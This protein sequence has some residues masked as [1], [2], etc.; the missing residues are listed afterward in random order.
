MTALLSGLYVQTDEGKVLPYR[1]SHRRCD[2]SDRAERLELRLEAGERTRWIEAAAREG[3]FSL[4]DWMRD[5]LNGTARSRSLLSSVCQDWNTPRA[6]LDA[7]APMGRI[8]LDPCSNASSIVR[9]R[10]KWTVADDGLPR[11]WRRHGLVY[12]NSPYGDA[13]PAWIAKCELEAKRGVEI[14]A[15]FPARPDT[16]WFERAAKRS[17]V[18]LLRGRLRF[19]GA[20]HGAPF[21]SAVAYWGRRRSLFR[22]TLA[23]HAVGFL[24]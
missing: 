5:R 14:V 13:L 2:A 9:A 7:I 19:L 11:D 22:R 12:V 8:G 23:R 20:R 3:Y 4:S 16:R 1:R 18:A 24:G 17:L 6:L 15:L 10:V 21:P